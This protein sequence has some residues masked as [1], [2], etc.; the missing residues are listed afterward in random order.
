MKKKKKNLAKA[1]PPPPPLPVA[2]VESPP[3]PPPPIHVPIPDDVLREILLL[4]PVKSL[5]R[6]TCICKSWK[7]IIFDLQFVKLHL[8]RSSA[9]NSAYFAHIQ[10]LSVISNIPPS[11]FNSH[12]SL[13]SVPLLFSP[14]YPKGHFYQPIPNGLCLIGVCNGL[15]CFAKQKNNDYSVCLWNPATRLWSKMSPPLSRQ[16]LSYTTFGFGYDGVNNT[17]KVV[18]VFYY[19]RSEDIYNEDWRSVVKI[20]DMGG[21]CWRNIQSFPYWQ[22][23]SDYNMGVYN[24]NRRRFVIWQMKEF[25]AHESWIKLFNFRFEEDLKPMSPSS[26]VLSENEEVL[27]MSRDQLVLYNQRDST[28]NVREVG[29]YRDQLALTYRKVQNYV[30]SLVSPQI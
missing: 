4:L 13:S 21:S 17:Y 24:F 20:Y 16:Y 7:L 29:N 10:L 12:A 19:N 25:G 15:V 5:V 27:L 30:E 6:F 11:S 22:R 8:S 18:A 23:A 9:N 14:Q 28:F 2:D 1:K 3:P 26:F